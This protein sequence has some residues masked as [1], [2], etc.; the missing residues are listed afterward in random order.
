[1]ALS[2]LVDKLPQYY[3]ADTD[4]APPFMPFIVAHVESSQDTLVVGPQRVAEAH[5]KFVDSLYGPVSGQKIEGMTARAFLFNSQMCVAVL[6]PTSLTDEGGRSGLLLAM[7]FFVKGRQIRIQSS[8]L[9]DY[10]RI[11]LQTINRQFSLSLPQSGADRLTE[12]IREVKEGGQE[13]RDSLFRLQAVMDALLLAS[14]AVGQ[15]SR[16]LPWWYKLPRMAPR[17]EVPKTIYYQDGA[18]YDDVL[19][20]FLKELSR[21]LKKFGKTGVLSFPDE[22]IEV[23]GLMTL[24]PFKG[25]IE[26]AKAVRLGKSRGRTYLKI[27]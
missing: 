22:A 1:M 18:A 25:P 16:K 8:T 27:Y 3:E 24:V 20:I 26:D 12:I 23:K 15:V 7:G 10:L 19:D 17:R 2:V 21:G 13:H 5:D 14:T 6:L 11:F 9:A 4:D